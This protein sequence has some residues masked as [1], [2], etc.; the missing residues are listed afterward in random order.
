MEKRSVTIRQ[1]LIQE[2]E[3]LAGKDDERVNR[4]IA[5][6][7]TAEELL[8]KECG[9]WSV[10]VPSAILHTLSQSPR[11]GMAMARKILLKIGLRTVQIDEICTIVESY[12]S[13][14]ANASKNLMIVHDAVAMG[15]LPAHAIA[16]SA[17]KVSFSIDSLLTPTALDIAAAMLAK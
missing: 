14:D 3:T 8:K 1:L 11:E 10:V 9:D 16:D 13:A 4:T 15:H 12:A 7:R 2:I 6:L 17:V 5:V